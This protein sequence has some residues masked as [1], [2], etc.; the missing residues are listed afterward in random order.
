MAPKQTAVDLAPQEERKLEKAQDPLAV[1]L[2]QS[3]GLL[4]PDDYDPSEHEQPVIRYMQLRQKALMGERGETVRTPGRF[5]IG[6]VSDLSYEDRDELQLTVLL[7]RKTRVYFQKL[8]DLKP[9]CRSMDMRFGSH[10]REGD[11]YGECAT[12]RLSQWGSGEG[13]R[14]ACREQRKIFAFDWATEKR[15]MLTLGPSSLKPWAIHNDYVDGAAAAMKSGGAVPFIHHLLMVKIE[16]EF[17]AEPAAHYVVKFG[18]VVPLPVKVQEQMI[19]FRKQ[20]RL[21]FQAAVER[22][23]EEAE[24][25]VG[26]DR[27]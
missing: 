6:S 27:E 17:R 11:R 14:Q 12:C 8:G 24:D 4:T 9:T 3:A 22:H 2:A 19:E 25:Y 21:T 5:R 10:A 16:S 15:I 7:F 1:A 18:Q 23:E 20:A 26:E 13:G